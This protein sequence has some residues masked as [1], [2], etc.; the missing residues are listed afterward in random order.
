MLFE[1][2]DSAGRGCVM[3]RRRV[4]LT[5]MGFGSF[6]ALGAMPIGAYETG[7][8]AMLSYRG[9]VEGDSD[10]VCDEGEARYDIVCWKQERL[11]L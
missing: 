8:M 7:L 4:V 3:G 5:M 6:E 11:Q 1:A 2:C 9:R 10:G